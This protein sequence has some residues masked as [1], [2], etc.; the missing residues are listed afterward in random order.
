LLGSGGLP[1]AEKGR[2]LD[3]EMGVSSTSSTPQGRRPSCRLF[4]KLFSFS[5]GSA[6]FSAA[7]FVAREN[8]P[9]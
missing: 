6:W 5:S 3:G 7:F 8:R 2:L 4:G 1:L 9:N